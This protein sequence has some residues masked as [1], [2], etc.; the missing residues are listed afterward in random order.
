MTPFP[1]IPPK[2]R[3]AI[4]ATRVILDTGHADVIFDT[5]QAAMDH[6]A[7]ICRDYRYRVDWWLRN[8]AGG[9]AFCDQ[10]SGPFPTDSWPGSQYGGHWDT[11]PNRVLEPGDPS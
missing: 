11:C 1:L 6:A 3:I 9:P 4:R 7:H 8:E 5:W 2:P 10:C